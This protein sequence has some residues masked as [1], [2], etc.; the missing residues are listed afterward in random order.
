MTNKKPTKRSR[1]KNASLVPKYNSRVRQEFGD[2]DYLDKLNDE[3]KSWL[4]KFTAEYLNA[5]VSKDDKNLLHDYEDHRKG[6]YNANNARNRDMY[7]LVKAKVAETKLLNYEDSARIVEEELSRGV[8]AANMENA[9]I[10]FIDQAQ[11]A[12]IMKE[13]REAMLKFTEATG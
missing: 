6:I 9:Y 1:V 13:Y 12:A 3:E 5:E 4:A 11:V 2:Y 8:N 7:G 10:D